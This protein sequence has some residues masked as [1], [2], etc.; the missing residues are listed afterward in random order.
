MTNLATTKMSSKG[1][2]V[3]PESIRQQLDLTT[4]AQFVVISN[5]KDDI[6]ILKLISEKDFQAYKETAY[7]MARPKNAARLNKSI[8]NANA[9]QT[10][11]HRL[12]DE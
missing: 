2:V 7:L 10:A 4:G 5:P 8:A 6:V 9:G 11:Q 12:L 1:Q 3:I